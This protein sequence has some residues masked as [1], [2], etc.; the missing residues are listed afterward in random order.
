MSEISELAI[1][2]DI[3]FNISPITL[4]DVFVYLAQKKI[5]NDEKVV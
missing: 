2:K 4:D 1:K 5:K 3:S